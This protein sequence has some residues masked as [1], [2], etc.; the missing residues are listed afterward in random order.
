MG[1]ST[2]QDILE[3]FLEA[4]NELRLC[5]LIQISMDGPNVNWSFLEKISAYLKLNCNSTMLCLGSCGLHVIN[6]ALQTG[7]KASQWNV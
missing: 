3:D 7:H 1:H 5:N 4:S 2:A 6:G